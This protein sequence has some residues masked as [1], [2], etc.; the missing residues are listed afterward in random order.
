[1]EDYSNI[2]SRGVQMF[3]IQLVFL[4]VAGLFVLLRVYVRAVL[5]KKL[6]YLVY[7]AVALDGIRNG[8]TGKSLAELEIDDA[9]VSL[10]AWYICEVLYA[11]TTLAIRASVCVLLLRLASNK[12]HRWIIWINLAVVS[13]V[14]IAFF[15]LLVFQCSPVHFFWRQLYGIQGTCID[16]NIVPY[17]T[18]AHSVISALS[19]W[20]LG[21][22][23]IAL[24]WNVDINRRTKVII[25]ILLSM[26][27]VFY[28]RQSIWSIME[29][30]LGI[31]AACT[32]TFRPLFKNWGFGWTSKRDPRD[33]NIHSPDQKSTELSST[34]HT[35]SKHLSQLGPSGESQM[36][37]NV[38]SI[39][40]S[41]R[42]IEKGQIRVRS[43]SPTYRAYSPDGPRDSGEGHPDM[44]APPPARR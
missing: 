42:D 30:A 37:L 6:I 22:L 5:V 4:I 29:P 27:M 40:S 7:G 16:H 14:S 26:G 41:P 24:L 23:P 3:Y 25:A 21:L 39:P 35:V 15:F 28:M 1:M 34:T 43:P 8:A 36:E 2:K 10:R 31:I 20:C 19:D 12:I 11:P 9:A 13:V 18:I 17:A 33:D 38:V 44:P 32:A